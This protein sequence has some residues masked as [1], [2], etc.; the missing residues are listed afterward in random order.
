MKHED[1]HDCCHREATQQQKPQTIDP[2]AN[3]YTCPMHPEIT[4]SSPGSCRLCGMALEPAHVSEQEEVNPELVDF[5]RRL[6]M[7][8]VFTVPLLILVMGE[9]LPGNPLNLVSQS[10]TAWIQLALASPVLFYCGY[11]FFQRAF[12]SIRTR[13]F[14]MF[15]LIGLGTGVAYGFS[16]LATLTPS[17]LPEEFKEHGRLPIYY[18]AS[19]SIITLV[20]I[21]QIL[22]LKARA[23]TSSAIRSLLKLAPNT[24]LVIA[25][26]GSQKEVDIS[27]VQVGAKVRVRPGEQIPVDGVV[28]EGTSSVDESMI[29][30]EPIAV[31]KQAQAKVIAGTT[32]QIGTLIIEAKGVGTDT[33]LSQIVRLV[34]E[35]QRSR[36]PIQ[37]LADRVS[38]W[39]VPAV[40]ISAIL[41]AIAWALLGPDPKLT[42]AVVNSVAVLIIA[43]PCALGLATPMSIMVGTGRGARAGVLIR[44][45]ESLETLAQVDTLVFDKTGTLTEGK[46]KVVQIATVNGFS[47]DD[48]LTAA[49]SLEKASEHPLGLAILEEAKNRSL[50]IENS[51]N[52]SIFSGE[53]I[54]G[55]VGNN[56]VLVGNKKLLER[57]GVLVTELTLSKGAHKGYTYVFVAIEGKLAGVIYIA[58]P[59][60]TNAKEVVSKLKNQGLQV[61]MLTGD[62]TTT[63]KAVAHTIGIDEVYAE[64]LPDQKNN[65]IRTLQAKSKVAMIGDGINDAPALAQADVG[66]AMGTGTDIAMQSAGITL[67]SGDLEGILRARKLS[68]S[69]IHNIK[70]NLF[71]AFAY[72]T[73]G[74][75]IA[76]GILYPFFGILLSPM[77]AS[78][79]MSLSSVSVIANAL[80]LRN[81]NL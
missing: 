70:Q 61:V 64:V 56:S 39:F 63:A 35:A 5:S 69:T 50:K 59:I 42:Y 55:V 57:A 6:K 2:L 25:P 32:N 3:H 19:A 23:Q 54:K 22:E 74:V 52:L 17:L 28:L 80:R 34:N 27:E 7:S 29:S 13:N 44:N 33:L 66:I 37:G 67:V 1:I 77:F 48:L 78:A 45:A 51:T 8:L 36:A 47:E 24:A 65:I 75:P 53:G 18:E 14:N 71:F 10:I 11:P 9:M 31:Q 58:D 12:D 76:A 16:L 49:S 81:L 68:I 60:K 21:G 30:G 15:T 46:P 79:A 4:Q 26:D 73:I 38:S 20:L 72:N 43:C 40:V 62:S 41:T